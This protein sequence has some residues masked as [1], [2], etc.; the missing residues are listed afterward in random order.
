MALAHDC[1]I[2]SARVMGAKPTER[3]AK[4]KLEGKQVPSPTG[5]PEKMKTD[6]ALKWMQHTRARI[7]KEI[8]KEKAKKRVYDKKL[9]KKKSKACQDLINGLD[10][11]IADID[12]TITDAGKVKSKKKKSEVMW[13]FYRSLPPPVQRV[14]DEEL[15]INAFAEPEVGEGYTI[16]SG[17]K[18]FPKSETWNFHWAGVVMKSDQGADKIT[19]ENDASTRPMGENTKW[20]FQMYGQADQSFHR[21]QKAEKAYGKHPTTMVVKKK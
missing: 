12:K 10:K 18:D 17:G 1:G 2:S 8:K 4:F 13:R 15:G 9:A 21:E 7:L 19:L 3:R 14:A 11:L 6:I 20:R 5:Y 16:S